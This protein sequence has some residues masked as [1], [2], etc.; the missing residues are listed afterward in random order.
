MWAGLGDLSAYLIGSGLAF[1][2][3][4][5]KWVEEISPPQMVQRCPARDITTSLAERGIATLRGGTVPF[6][7]AIPHAEP[8]YERRT[9]TQSGFDPSNRLTHF[10]V[11]GGGLFPADLWSISSASE[12]CG[13]V[14]LRSR[15]V[16][17]GPEPGPPPRAFWQWSR[18][19]GTHACQWVK[20][21]PHTAQQVE[22]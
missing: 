6:P 4:A 8:P 13:Y 17:P 10:A 12:A 21:R 3:Q 14:P 15:H 7:G 5:E 9:P 16:T 2:G 19:H 20:R 22:N 18:K 11:P 1:W